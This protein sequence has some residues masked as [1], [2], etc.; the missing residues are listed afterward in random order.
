MSTGIAAQA[1]VGRQQL[2]Q[3]AA[4]AGAW[5]DHQGFYTATRRSSSRKQHRPARPGRLLAARAQSTAVVVESSAPASTGSQ[6]EAM[7]TTQAVLQVCTKKSCCRNGAMAT[8]Q[9]LRDAAPEGVE[10][11]E[12]SKCMD[13]CKKGPNVRV[14]PDGEIVSGVKTTEQVERLLE[15]HCSGSNLAQRSQT[16]TPQIEAQ[17]PEAELEMYKMHLNAIVDDMDRSKREAVLM[18]AMRIR[19]EGRTENFLDRQYASSKPTM[20]GKKQQMMVQEDDS[21]S[22]SS[23][24]ESDMEMETEMAAQNRKQMKEMKKQQEMEKKEMKKRE[25]EMKKTAKASRKEREGAVTAC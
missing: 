5:S 17:S 20:Q 25:K 9:A 13:L 11:Q 22:S 6:K 14:W 7:T 1:M 16:I 19:D 18:E 12:V 21:S 3:A 2:G 15:T 23:E 8:L 10:V 4:A 24:S